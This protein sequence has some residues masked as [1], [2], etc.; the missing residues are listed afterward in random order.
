MISSETG[1]CLPVSSAMG[2]TG[3]SENEAIAMAG[4]IFS[5]A[6]VIDNIAVIL[7]IDSENFRKLLQ[8]IFGFQGREIA[9]EFTDDNCDPC[10][11]AFDRLLLADAD[12]S[13][14][15]L[16]DRYIVSEQFAVGGGGNFPINDTTKRKALEPSTAFLAMKHVLEPFRMR[17]GFFPRS[18]KIAKQSWGFSIR[19][20]ISVVGDDYLRNAAEF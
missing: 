12:L 18:T 3:T 7:E 1:C 17:A 11:G 5:P 20:A 14:F 13:D 15:T 9:F 16:D 6:M 19:N 10:R 4:S 8:G 2:D